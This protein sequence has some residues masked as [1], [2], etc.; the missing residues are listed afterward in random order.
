MQVLS[1]N[2]T[3][4]KETIQNPYEVFRDWFERFGKFFVTAPDA[5][6]LEFGFK[7]FEYGVSSANRVTQEISMEELERQVTDW[8]FK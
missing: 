6:L 5:S 3:W 2:I 1:Q 4:E 7:A 8:E